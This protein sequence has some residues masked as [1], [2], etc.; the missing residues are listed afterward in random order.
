M[1]H[2]HHLSVFWYGRTK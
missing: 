2:P 1:A